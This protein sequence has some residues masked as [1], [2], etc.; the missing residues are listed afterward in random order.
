MTTA[1]SIDLS[2]FVDFEPVEDGCWYR[3]SSGDHRIGQPGQVVGVI[4]LRHCSAYE[5]V[6]RHAC[7]KTDS[8]SPFNLLPM[9]Q[10]E[11]SLIVRQL[12]LAL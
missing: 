12:Q 8:Y 3:V 5:V 11:V 9:T 7:G 4:R 2:R 10:E 1:G 6:L